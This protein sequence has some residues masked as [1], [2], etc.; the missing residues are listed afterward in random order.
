MI[1]ELIKENENHQSFIKDLYFIQKTEELQAGLWPQT[2]LNPILEMQF[3]AQEKSYKQR[4]PEAENWII[5]ADDKAVGWILLDKTI[6]YHIISIIVH[7]NHRQKRIGQ[8]A[9]RLISGLAQNDNK[10]VTLIVN[11]DNP[12][13]SLYHKMGLSEVKADEMHVTM[14]TAK[15][16]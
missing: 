11:K 16:F 2:M 13:I 1:I 4:F 14:S 3:R 15:H 6:T 5:T 9:I 10:D 8:K 12:A 7:P